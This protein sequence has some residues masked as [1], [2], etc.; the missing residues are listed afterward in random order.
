MPFTSEINFI[1]RNDNTTSHIFLQNYKKAKIHTVA[2]F[3]KGTRCKFN[4]SNL[5]VVS[6]LTKKKKHLKKDHHYNRY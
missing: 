4:S 6:K 3:I 1:D 2:T 5:K